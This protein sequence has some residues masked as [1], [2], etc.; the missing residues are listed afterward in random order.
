MMESKPEYLCMI[1]EAIGRM[2]T[3]SSILKGFAATVVTGIAAISFTDVNRYVLLLSI[4][5]IIS[6]LALDVYYLQQ[7]RRFRYL[8]DM[9]RQDKHDVDFAMKVDVPREAIKSAE[10]RI[11]DCVRSASLWLFYLPTVIVLGLIVV[12]KFKGVI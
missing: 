4:C 12:M 3:T 9:V 6:F 1:Q 11:R 5:P 8:F 10:I 7:E 2:S